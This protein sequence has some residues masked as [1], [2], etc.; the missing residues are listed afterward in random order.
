MTH[1]YAVDSLTDP[2]SNLNPLMQPIADKL[3]ELHKRYSLHN[4]FFM[5]GTFE[6]YAFW[7]YIDHYAIPRV[8]VTRVHN[9]VR[10]TLNKNMEFFY[11]CKAYPELMKANWE[12][13]D[14]DKATGKYSQ[15][16]MDGGE[17]KFLPS[18]SPELE[19]T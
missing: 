13:F 5:G 15:D 10:Y 8:K 1:I 3:Y 12:W 7:L 19:M 14:C 17:W 2:K 6:R 11:A 4:T 9:K 16:D 18:F